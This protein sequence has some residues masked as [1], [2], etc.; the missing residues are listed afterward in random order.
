MTTGDEQP[1]LDSAPCD[2]GAYTLANSSG[3][4]SFSVVL[5]Y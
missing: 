3:S 5:A 1:D 4:S 2:A